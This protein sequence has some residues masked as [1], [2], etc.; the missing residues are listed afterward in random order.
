M[1]NV[2]PG[3]RC[4]PLP[5]P[6]P[7]RKPPHVHVG[8]AQRQHSSKGASCSG[9][10][11]R[12]KVRQKKKCMPLE[13]RSD[14]EPIPHLS[15]SRLHQQ[16]PTPSPHFSG[17][18][19]Q[20]PV[21]IPDHPCQDASDTDKTRT[22]EQSHARKHR[23]KKKCRKRNKSSP[24]RP[25]GPDQSERDIMDGPGSSYPVTVSEHYASD[26]MEAEGLGYSS[27]RSWMQTHCRGGQRWQAT[28]R[29][30]MEPVHY[31]YQGEEQQQPWYGTEWSHDHDRYGPDAYSGWYHNPYSHSYSRS[32]SYCQ[33]HHHDDVDRQ[34][35]RL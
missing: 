15:D 22:R 10:C 21:P 19:H 31:H 23:R 1:C 7:P 24:Y 3:I 20:D 27:R 12:Q 2:L 18:Y 11:D 9:T 17:C 14:L 6:P 16:G 32:G 25:P 4:P 33:H 8:G 13:V 28:R 29:P 30:Q 35:E 26:C 34:S 5:P